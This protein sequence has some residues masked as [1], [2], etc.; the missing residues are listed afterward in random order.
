MSRI[1]YRSV[2]EWTHCPSVPVTPLN[3]ALMA[4]PSKH[5]VVEHLE[6]IHA[7]VFEDFQSVITAIVNRR[8]G[9]YALY[10]GDRLYYVG[11]AR[12]LKAR[13]R[14][15][16]R[17]RHKGLWD[18]FSVYLT[19]G[20]SHMKELESLM[21]RVIKPVGNRVK[22]KLKGSKDQRRELER[23][24]KQDQELKRR[25]ILGKPIQAE[26]A[27]RK[28]SKSSAFR[29]HGANGAVFLRA[30]Y[31]GKEFKATLNRDGSVRVGTKRF[32]SLSAAGV[33]VTKRGTNGRHFWRARN[34][35]GEWVPIGTL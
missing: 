32:N 12:N 18:R 31:K 11:L 17:D 34:A 27:E 3:I 6:A 30:F 8:N 4:A 1:G 25:G 5:L 10:S 21:L 19:D 20:D 2:A 26:R 16:L 7:E 13:L 24:I 33:S 23:R 28:R 22:G 35:R 15:H 9:V 29:R 14:A